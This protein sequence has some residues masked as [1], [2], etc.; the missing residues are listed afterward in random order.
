VTIGQSTTE[1]LYL[2]VPAGPGIKGHSAGSALSCPE[3]KETNAAIDKV[4]RQ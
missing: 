2:L 3:F 4:G 1:I